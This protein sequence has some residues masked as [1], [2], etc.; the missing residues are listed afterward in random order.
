[1]RK[2]V[3]QCFTCNFHRTELY[4]IMQ[5]VNL[6]RITIRMVCTVEQAWH[7]SHS[8]LENIRFHSTRGFNLI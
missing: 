1:M 7:K 4:R 6:F 2:Y 5:E 8:C 3:Q